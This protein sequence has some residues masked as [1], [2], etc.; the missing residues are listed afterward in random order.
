MLADHEEFCGAEQVHCELK[1]GSRVA[2]AR[3]RAHQTSTCPRR[4]VSCAYCARAFPA[5]TLQVNRA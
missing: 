4:L 3:L 5:D 1:C 2:R